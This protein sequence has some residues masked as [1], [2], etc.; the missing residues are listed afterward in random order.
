MS[1]TNIVT[2]NDTVSQNALAPVVVGLIRALSMEREA[3][4]ST[5]VVLREAVA[6]MGEQDRQID[7]ERA[8]RLHLLEQYRELV[9]RPIDINTEQKRAA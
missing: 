8:S 7:R 1:D 9:G 3:H 6:M 2:E 4:E 5:R